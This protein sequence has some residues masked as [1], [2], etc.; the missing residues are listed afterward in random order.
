MYKG[1]GKFYQGHRNRVKLSLITRKW[2]ATLRN[3]NYT[4]IRLNQE[5]WQLYWGKWEGGWLVTEPQGNGAVNVG[6]TVRTLF[7]WHVPSRVQLHYQ[8]QMPFNAAAKKSSVLINIYLT[9]QSHGKEGCASNR[10]QM[11]GLWSSKKK[12]WICYLET[13]I[14]MMAIY[15]R[16]QGF[17][18]VIRWWGG[19][20]LAH[21]LKGRWNCKKG[22]E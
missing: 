3:Q 21:D 1:F 16:L 5:Y 9:Q 22:R 10:T 19:G 13:I 17:N 6:S 18:I 12:W 20:K 2:L 7:T 8:S 14:T 15:A 4:Q 11:S